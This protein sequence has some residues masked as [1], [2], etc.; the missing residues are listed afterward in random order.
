MKLKPGQS[1]S[2][3]V[4][5]VV[6]AGTAAG[7]YYLAGSLAVGTLGDTTAADGLAVSAVPVTVS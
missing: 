5:F 3:R 1:T 6:P 4:K 2:Y 7:S